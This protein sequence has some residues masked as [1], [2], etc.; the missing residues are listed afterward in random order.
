[1]HN[2]LYGIWVIYVLNLFQLQ[3]TLS[4]EAVHQFYLLLF[5]FDT[6]TKILQTDSFIFHDGC[7]P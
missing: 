5:R 7:P 1:M 4:F 2:L 6:V 3:P